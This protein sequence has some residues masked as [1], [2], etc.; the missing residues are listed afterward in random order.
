[1][2]TT[3]IPT[4]FVELGLPET[5]VETI[6]DLGYETP[7]AIQSAAIP[8][9]LSGRDL[10]GQ[11]QTGTG[12]TAAFALP[13]LAKVDLSRRTPQILVLTPTRELAIQVA[14]AFKSYA[15]KLPLFQVLPIYGGQSMGSQLRQLERGPHVIV[16]TP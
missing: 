1:M 11:A 9:L 16:G 14:E 10:V 12:K 15:R 5:L 13:F 4:T 6:R 7:T 8:V 3:E 2:K